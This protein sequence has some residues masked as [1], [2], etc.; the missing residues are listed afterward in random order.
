MRVSDKALRC[1]PA[2]RPCAAAPH[3]G[4]PA[5]RLDQ[6]PRYASARKKPADPRIRARTPVADGTAPEFLPDR[7]AL[8]RSRTVTCSMRTSITRCQEPREGSLPSCGIR[9][10]F[11]LLASAGSRILG[12]CRQIYVLRSNLAFLPGPV[13]LPAPLEPRS[14][15][16]VRVHLTRRETSRALVAGPSPTIVRRRGGWHFPRPLCSHQ[17]KRAG[18]SSP[19]SRSRRLT[20]QLAA[21]P[22]KIASERPN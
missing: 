16:G 17:K 4:Q 8:P 14:T 21:A 10:G 20:D 18:S 22:R 9:T 3:E 7:S 1:A 2:A 6:E 11:A 5:V 15:L 19:R 12:R 13:D